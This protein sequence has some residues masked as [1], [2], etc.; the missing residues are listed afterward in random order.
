[1]EITETT[2]DKTLDGEGAWVLRTPFGVSSW[3]VSD[4]V[5]LFFTNDENAKA[6]EQQPN[7]MES[8]GDID[9]RYIRIEKLKPVG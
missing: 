9:L 2:G 1:M 5:K 6:W 8:G 4:H 3:M 7:V